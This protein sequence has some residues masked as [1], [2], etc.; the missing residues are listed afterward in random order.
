MHETSLR[1]TP[2]KPLHLKVSA[3]CPAKSVQPFLEELRHLGY[4]L[5]VEC[6]LVR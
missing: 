6:D 3:A 1:V 4:V 5:R 2:S